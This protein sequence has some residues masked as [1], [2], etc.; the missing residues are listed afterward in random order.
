M[1]FL[2][3]KR[4]VLTLSGEE[5]EETAISGFTQDR[6]T[7]LAANVDYEQLLQ[8]RSYTIINFLN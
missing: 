5:V 3:L 7:F 4:R 1:H 6:H 2:P 8:V